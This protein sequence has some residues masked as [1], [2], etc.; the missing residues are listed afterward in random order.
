[1]FDVIEPILVFS[2]IG[3]AGLLLALRTVPADERPWLRNKL[4][5]ALALRMTV[6]TFFEIFRDFRIFHED[7]EGYEYVAV[8]LARSWWGS[9]PPVDMGSTNT[10]FYYLAGTVCF[11]FGPYK[12]SVAFFNSLVGT[13]TAFL[14]YRAARDLVHL[15]VARM[16]C[17]LVAFTPSMILWSS[18]ALKDAVTTFLIVVCLISCMKLKKSLSVQALA[19]IVLST[20]AVQPIRF[21]L[22]YFMV[23]AV[24]GS[25]VIDRGLRAVTGIYKQIFLL[26]AL[27]GLFTITGLSGRTLEST[28]FLSFEKVSAYRE[29]LATSARS[30]FDQKVD[31]ST[32]GKA[33][34]FMPIG[35]ANLLL[36]PFPWQMTSVRA[37]IALPETFAWW[38]LFPATIRGA[39]FLAR[40]RM[41]EI[42]PVLLFA[43]TLICAYSLVH[44]NIGS[45]FRQRS[46]IFV[47]LFIF[48]AVGWYQ[49]KCRDVGIDEVH[50]LRPEPAAA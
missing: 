35:I 45:G 16:A 32:P 10:G 17:M 13:A 29:G 11:L 9:G 33:L 40:R 15:R 26:A 37:L 34:A 23:F 30:G 7:S 46:Q 8:A 49:K 3:T 39:V 25:F 4:F 44:G 43:I 48:S 31:I 21:Y 42:A 20:M 12:V 22:V 1:V 5:I 41:S 18:I 19:G 36:G 47:F 38:L 50:L 6:A 27:F 28:E 2:F 24:V 14:I